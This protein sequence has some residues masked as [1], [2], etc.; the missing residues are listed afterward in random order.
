MSRNLVYGW[1][2]W[3]LNARPGM[4]VCMPFLAFIT[5]DGISSSMTA[6]N[7][8]C[9]SMHKRYIPLKHCR[10]KGMDK[11]QIQ[12]DTVLGRVFPHCTSIQ[13]L[14][15]DSPRIP[16][17]PRSHS[18]VLT[19][20]SLLLLPSFSAGIAALL[21]IENPAWAASVS[22]QHRNAKRTSVWKKVFS[23]GF[24]NELPSGWLRNTSAR[25]THVVENPESDDS[26]QNSSYASI[27]LLHVLLHL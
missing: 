15:L 7:P 18:S 14:E 23:L 12:S 1:P 11:S 17:Y 3:F 10:N 8:V 2:S 20:S 4:I 13:E 19:L 22:R 9:P 16:I 24:N 5:S 27:L 25:V 6:C 21:L 26:P